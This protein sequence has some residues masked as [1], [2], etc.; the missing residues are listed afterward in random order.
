MTFETGVKIS[1]KNLENAIAGT[2]LHVVQKMDEVDFY[3]E[4]VEE[5]LERALKS[6]KTEERGVH[7]QASTLGS[8]EA[9]MEF[10]RV[11]KIPVSGVSVGPV[12]RK[13]VIK[14]STQLQHDK[15]YA[16]LLAF[17]VK[18]DQ[19]ARLMAEDLGI[20]IFTADIIYHLFDQFTEHM[21]DIKR[22]KK[23]EFRH[24]AMFPCRLKIMPD[25]IFNTRDPI[26]MGVDVID[27]ILKVGTKICV[28]GKEHV[29][30]GIVHGI[31]LN[32]K[33]VEFA[34]K[35][36][37]VCVKLVPV[38]GQAP[39]MFDRHFT[40]DDELVSK[41]SRQS[42]DVLKDYFR[43]E[44]TPEDWRLVKALKKVFDIM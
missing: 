25:N 22:Q 4:A 38:P 12:H 10:L 7:V 29:E 41:I 18:V 27:G 43:D 39:K 24:L 33:A 31:E 13:D 3:K 42:I 16:L 44:M 35:G 2:Q 1:A 28:P 23:E 15:T 6:I 5:D 11:S 8:L 19:D 21:E 17:D 32:H 37:A 40:K 34:R 20:K 26:V 14:T 30:I 36:A 9:L